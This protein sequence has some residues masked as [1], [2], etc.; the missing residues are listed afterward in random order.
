MYTRSQSRR[1]SVIQRAWRGFC[2]LRR[3]CPISLATIP[4][5]R[6]F[7]VG[8]QVYDARFLSEYLQASG[9]YRCPITRTRIAPHLLSRLE[10]MT[11]VPVW[12]DRSKIASAAREERERADVASFY[13]NSLEHH[14][15][16]C[17]TA[18]LSKSMPGRQ[19]LGAVIESLRRFMATAI[20]YSTVDRSAALTAI[21]RAEAS[22]TQLITFH[23]ISQNV[24]IRFIRRFKDAAEGAAAIAP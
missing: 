15:G 20:E 10:T 6:V 8:K 7:R 3:R 14:M 1:A 5:E 16:S 24:A 9:D 17:T 4:A 22:L 18:L 11:G 12:T 21:G 23:T 19:V 13:V 2:A